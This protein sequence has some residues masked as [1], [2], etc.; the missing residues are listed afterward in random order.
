MF[1]AT[2][3]HHAGE[4]S[5]VTR[6][7]VMRALV[8]GILLVFLM[9][10]AACNSGQPAAEAE[11]APPTPKALLAGMKINE[12]TPNILYTYMDENRSF[13]TVESADEV[14]DPF[15]NDVVVVDLSLPPERRLASTQVVVADLNNKDDEGYF[16]LRIEGRAPFEESLRLKR[17]WRLS[18]TR[19]P[20]P[21]I[22]TLGQ[23][24]QIV[25]P[26]D[27][28]DTVI[29]YSAS[30]CSYCKRARKW[31]TDN[32]VPFIERDIEADEQAARELQAKCH[33]AKATCNGVP[34][35]DWKGRLVQGFDAKFVG[36]LL[37]EDQEKAAKADSEESKQPKP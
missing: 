18:P 34:V 12:Q 31:L 8:S 28:S 22:D 25:P 17:E 5:P 11:D 16:N 15:R 6:S 33:M 23:A 29:L 26:D 32:K 13:V 9:S 1:Q 14:P 4:G 3:F 37:K 27:E 30:W 2:F 35:I 7:S 24:A 36:S 21:S 19:K 10:L 20:M